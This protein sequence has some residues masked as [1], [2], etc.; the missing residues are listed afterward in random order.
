MPVLVR[1]QLRRARIDQ[2]R[3]A[4]LA[5][6]ILSAVDEASATLSV[7]LIGDRAMQGLNRRYR[8]QNRTT[9]VLAFSMREGPGPSSQL[10][11]DV[12]I[13]VPTAAKQAG[14]LGRSLDEELTTLLVHGILHLCGYDHERSAREARRM[15]GRERFVLRRLGRIPRLAYRGG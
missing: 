10:I 4:R 15:Q 5:Q 7:V 1:S 6:A 2:P 8:K 11:G 12:V 13:S 3:L 14:H 9:D